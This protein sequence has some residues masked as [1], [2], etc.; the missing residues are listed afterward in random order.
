MLR[1]LLFGFSAMFSCLFCWFVCLVLVFCVLVDL[2][3]VFAYLRL[4]V[5][6]VLDVCVW[7]GFQ[8][9]GVF[10]GCVYLYALLVVVFG[11]CLC[12]TVV[13]LC[14]TVVCFDLLLGCYCCFITCWFMFVSVCLVLELSLLFAFGFEVCTLVCKF[15]FSVIWFW[16]FETCGFCGFMYLW[17]LLLA[18]FRC[19]VIC[20]FGVLGFPLFVLGYAV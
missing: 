15:G 18:G 2:L 4:F 16:V 13:C 8:V 11:C 1:G 20:D 6:V 17:C 10:G 14:L 5:L 19:F 7:F 12:L 9:W 3:R